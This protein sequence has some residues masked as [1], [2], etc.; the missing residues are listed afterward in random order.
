MKREMAV[1]FVDISAL[2]ARLTSLASSFLIYHLNIVLL[3]AFD[4]PSSVGQSLSP[5]T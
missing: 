2:D 4:V 3:A 1:S 5:F